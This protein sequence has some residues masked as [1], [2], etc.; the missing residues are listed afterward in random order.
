[1]NRYMQLSGVYFD[2]LSIQKSNDN[3]VFTPP[4]SNV[5]D[6]DDSEIEPA[7]SDYRMFVLLPR[8]HKRQ[9]RTQAERSRHQM[10]ECPLQHIGNYSE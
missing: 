6:F 7:S 2:L 8:F 3:G 9:E 4:K 10:R 5:C 1:M